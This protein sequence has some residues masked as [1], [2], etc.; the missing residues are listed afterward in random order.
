[1]SIEGA[2]VLLVESHH[3]KPVI[4][5]FGNKNSTYSDIGGRKDNDEKPE[6]IAI[7]EAREESCNLVQLKITDLA[8]AIPVTIKKY[9][10]YIIHVKG[11]SKRDY[12]YNR[13]RINNKCSGVW[14]ETNNMVRIPIDN[15]SM[16]NSGYLVDTE[17]R[18]IKIRG[19]TIKIIQSFTKQILSVIRVNPIKMK[20]NL[21]KKSRIPCLLGTVTYIS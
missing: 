14:K 16:I 4:T 7:R 1:M 20:R 2:G 11:L 21:T 17:G 8:K 12:L 3:S 6:E 15:L 19:R 5:L 10:C 18:A 9:R 13:K